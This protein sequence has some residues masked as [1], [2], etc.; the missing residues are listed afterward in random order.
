M[1]ERFII[2]LFRLVSYERLNIRSM[3]FNLKFSFDLDCFGSKRNEDDVL[4]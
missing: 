2:D 3:K 4:H 1:R